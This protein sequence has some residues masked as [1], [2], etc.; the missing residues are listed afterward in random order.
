MQI[1]WKINIPI[2][3]LF[4]ISSL[5]ILSIEFDILIINTNV[6]N[7]YCTS[8][9]NILQN[10]SYSIIGGS[11]M[12]F[13]TIFIP[14]YT[15]G[16]IY[17]L[18]VSIIIEEYYRG[19]MYQYFMY[20][21][22]SDSLIPDSK[23]DEYNIRYRN[24][25]E[26]ENKVNINNQIPVSQSNI[27]RLACLKLISDANKTFTQAIIPYEI[28]LSNKQLKLITNIRKGQISQI[29]DIFVSVYDEKDKAVFGMY[30]LMKGHIKMV[31]RLYYKKTDNPL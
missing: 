31:D 28:Y 20:C 21:A 10:I 13:L 27:K 24:F 19:T 29:I 18:L 5:I 1:S 12:Y 26:K 22:D 9:N 23:D 17:S 11:I 3:L 2:L 16:K 6:S 8:S 4:L 14:G 15:R 30:N 25:M 7:D